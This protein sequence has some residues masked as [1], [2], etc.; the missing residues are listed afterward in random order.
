L[1]RAGLDLVAGSVRFYD[2]RK[3]FADIKEPLVG[4]VER[5]ADVS[6]SLLENI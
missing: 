3:V 4:I 1:P 2:A 5:L 6:S